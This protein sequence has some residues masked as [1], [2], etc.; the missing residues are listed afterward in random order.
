MKYNV[1]KVEKKKTE[2]KS[3]L[4][5]MVKWMVF[6]YISHF[7]RLV[8]AMSKVNVKI[9]HKRSQ[10][11]HKVDYIMI[12]S[13]IC[14]AWA[15]LSIARI[16]SHGT[17]E[18]VQIKRRWIVVYVEDEST[19]LRRLQTNVFAIFYIKILECYAIFHLTVLNDSFK[20]SFELFLDWVG[21]FL[22]KI[23]FYP[24]KTWLNVNL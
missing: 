9:I 11:T 19:E 13:I 10:R 17:P 3:W 18:K 24:F 5:G 20:R 12:L 7:H 16:E 8:R 23:N 14:R 2:R 15:I 21:E 4:R 1:C 6:V 22:S